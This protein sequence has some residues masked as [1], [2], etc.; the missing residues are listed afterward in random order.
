M[1]VHVYAAPDLSD[2]SFIAKPVPV[3]GTPKE[4]RGLIYVG[5]GHYTGYDEESPRSLNKVS[6]HIINENLFV[7]ININDF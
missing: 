7:K 5:S 3:T 6:P 2:D 4:I 1:A